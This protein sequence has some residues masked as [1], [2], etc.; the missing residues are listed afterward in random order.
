MLAVLSFSPSSSFFG[1]P[2]EDEDKVEEEVEKERTID[3]ED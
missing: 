1:D 2:D 3:G